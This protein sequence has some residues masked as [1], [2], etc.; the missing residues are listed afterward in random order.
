MLAVL[1]G[2]KTVTSV[3]GWQPHTLVVPGICA[4]F[5]LIVFARQ[6]RPFGFGLCVGVLWSVAPT[7]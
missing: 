7:P 2:G 1:V 3:L 5:A 6:T 4:V